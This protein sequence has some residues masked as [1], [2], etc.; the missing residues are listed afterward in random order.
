[1]R[2][3]PG[4]QARPRTGTRSLSDRQPRRR[5]AEP[6]NVALGSVC[7]CETARRASRAELD[8]IFFEPAGAGTLTTR[9]RADPGRHHQA[10]PTA[11]RDR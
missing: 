2:G 4:Y 10:A 11:V 5:E 3:A 6:L 8:W 1:M 9:H 7:G